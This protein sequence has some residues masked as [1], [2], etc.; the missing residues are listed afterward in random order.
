VYTNPTRE[1]FSLGDDASLFSNWK[2]L[3]HSVTDEYADA[4]FTLGKILGNENIVK[5]LE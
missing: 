3:A 4:L 2:D 1:I 5:N